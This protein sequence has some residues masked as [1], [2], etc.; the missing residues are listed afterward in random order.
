[1]LCFHSCYVCWLICCRRL[2]HALK[3][4]PSTHVATTTYQQTTC[5]ILQIYTQLLYISGTSTCGRFERILD[6]K[7][8]E[9]ARKVLCK[10]L[11]NAKSKKKKKTTTTKT[12]ATTTLVNVAANK[13]S[14]TASKPLARTH[15]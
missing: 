11:R 7:I 15:T 3:L 8:Q 2:W 14:A 12:K 6:E 4:T 13:Y 1:M 5:N 10:Q 9:F